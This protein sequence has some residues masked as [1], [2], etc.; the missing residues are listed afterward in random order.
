M[1][2]KATAGA[3][4]WRWVYGAIV[5]G[6]AVLFLLSVRSVLSPLIAFGI[7]LLLAAP[8]AGTRR[9]TTLVIAGAVLLFLYM[10]QALGSLLTPFILA[11]VLAYI[12]DPVVD[13]IEQ[14]GMKRGLAVA[15]VMLPVIGL[16]VVLLVFGIPAIFQQLHNLLGGV[17]DAAVRLSAWLES[18]RARAL[19]A[20]LPFLSDEMINRWLDQARIS[21]YVRTQ[22]T[23]IVQKAWAAVTGVRKG[24]GLVLS[25]VG[26]LV[27]VPVLVIYLLRDFDR[28]TRSAGALVPE[29][30]R[31]GSFSLMREYDALLSRFL[32]GQVIAASIV[33]VLTWLGLWIAGVPYAALVGAI[34]GVFNLVPYLGLIVSIVPVLIIALISG[35]FLAVLAKAGIVFGIVQMIDGTITGPRIV[36]ESVGLHPV[37][38][39][40]ALA[41][42]SSL[43]GFTG[44]LIAMPAAVLVKLMIREGIVRYQRSTFFKGSVV[45]SD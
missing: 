39:L 23:A 26:L 28:I 42:G 19:A 45:E 27:L 1:N 40:L 12:L 35:S 31:A 43:F 21:E 8:Y 30:F 29:R 11:F 16:L 17:P 38:V 9:H 44:L 18:M 22:Q 5:L 32:R 6:A 3:F 41:I 20:N 13:F 10:F 36:G 14:R 37:W 15:L 7:L 2:F 4:E 25:L 24:L 33:G 34:A